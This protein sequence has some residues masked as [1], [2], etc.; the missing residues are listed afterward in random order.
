[1]ERSRGLN[2]PPCSKYSGYVCE[3]NCR[4]FNQKQK[5]II[6]ESAFPAVTPYDNEIE[7]LRRASPEEQRECLQK[8]SDFLASYCTASGPGE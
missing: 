1:M 2:D 7:M 5:S 3:R 4:L 8:V 6:R